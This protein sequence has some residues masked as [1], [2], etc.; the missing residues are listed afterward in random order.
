MATAAPFEPH[1]H[2][3][4]I[5]D[6]H[7]MVESGILSA[8][9]HVE[10]ITGE[11]IDMAPIGS[12][13]AGIVKKLSHLCNQAAAHAAIISVQDPVILSDLSE[14]QPDIALL[15][16]RDDFYSSAHPRAE[17]IYLIIEVADSTLRYDRT[18]KLPLYAQAEIPE[19]WIVNVEGKAL[20]IYRQPIDGTY[21]QQHR[22]E[23]LGEISLEA[24]PAITLD[25]KSLFGT[26]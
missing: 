4:S 17:E 18:V 10:L 6:Y 14:P 22:L 3:F 11:V 9:D 5:A 7:R 1:P 16:Y 24:L 8:Q 23:T 15:H 20:E 13:H 25:L 12:Q 26:G 2:G 21:Q 19:I